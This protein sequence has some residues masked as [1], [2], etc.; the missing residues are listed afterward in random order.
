M[1]TVECPE[2]GYCVEKRHA[3]C[4]ICQAELPAETNTDSA[5]PAPQRT[6]WLL[7]SA[8]FLG[9]I[10]SIGHWLLFAICVAALVAG[11]AALILEKLSA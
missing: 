6:S 8:G 9:G 11:V 10:F 5:K 7:F 3:Q 1:N 2:C 4:P